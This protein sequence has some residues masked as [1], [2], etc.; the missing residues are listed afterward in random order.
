MAED[1]LQGVERLM[2][3][4]AAMTHAVRKAVAPVVMGEAQGMAE[5]MKRIAPRDDAH[6]D[7]QK[8][9]EHIYAEEGRLGDISAVVIADAVDGKGRAKA[10]RV[11]LG[12]MAADGKIVPPSPFFY[13]VVRANRKRV[14]RNILKAMRQ[15]I[16][17]EAGL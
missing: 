5:Q 11:E 2:R 17:K 9:S 14:R 6:D 3:R 12:H 15:A 7:G 16:R 4:F 1:G 8:L 10:S 13:P